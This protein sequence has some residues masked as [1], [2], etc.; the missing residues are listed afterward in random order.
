MVSLTPADMVAV[1]RELCARSL[2]AFLRRAWSVID[3]GQPYVHNWH[4]EAVCEH[5]EALAKGELPSPRLLINVPPGTSKSTGVGIMFPAWLWGPFG[6]P[7]HRFIGASHDQELAIR[8]NR[9]TRM[10]I[11]SEW[12]QKLW[13]TALV[14]DQNEKKFFENASTGFRQAVAV[15]SMT[16]RRGDTVVWDDPHSPEKAYSDADRETAIRVF[17]ETLPNRLNNPDKSAIVVV[18]QR[19][20][21]QDVSG[22]ILES[23]YGYTHLMLPMEFESARRCYTSVKPRH[24]PAKAVRARYDA[25]RQSWYVEGQ[26]IPDQHEARVMDLPLQTVYNQD[27]RET[28]GEL[29]FEGRFPAEVV[30]RDKRVMGDFAT[31]GQLQQRPAPRGG[32]LFPVDRFQMMDVAPSRDDIAKLV[33]YWDKAGTAGA[34]AY[35]A[36]VLMAALKDGRYVVMHVYRKQLNALDREATI[37]RIADSDPAGTEI[38]VEQE[39]GSGGKESAE[40]TVRRLAGHVVKIDRVTG[41]KFHRAQPYA[42][43]QQGKNVFLVKAD[44]NRDFTD[45]HEHFPAGRYKDQV[46]AAAGA[47][48]KIFDEGRKRAGVLF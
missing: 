9:K 27:P 47:F 25:P 19:L 7:S 28:D 21:E 29:L 33:R 37:S 16:G 26:P 46:D 23:D 18:M 41:E 2:S 42:A 35:T 43:Q 31:A 40:A 6:N 32:G 20:H 12:Y 38:W 14:S 22:H 44:W 13:P 45:E 39:P 17:R 34:G 1:E 48:N 4:M 11:E 30:E 24:M 8:D 36:G 5:L 10:L 3:P 15:K